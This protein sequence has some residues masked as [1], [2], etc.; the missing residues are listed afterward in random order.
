MAH[1]MLKVGDAYRALRLYGREVRVVLAVSVL[2][3]AGVLLLGRYWPRTQARGVNVCKED[4][5]D[6]DIIFRRGVSAQSAAIRMADGLFAYSHVGII[7]KSGSNVEVIHASYEEEGQT[8]DGV[9]CEPLGEFLNP[10]SVGAA[11]VSRLKG[12]SREASVSALHEAERF[13]TAHTPFDE[14]FDLSSSDKLYCTEL[15]W[16][17]YKEAGV[18]LVDGKFDSLPLLPGG[19]RKPY[20]LPSSLFR[21][22]H[23]QTVWTSQDSKDSK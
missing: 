7:R 23:L 10:A 16:V 1:K 13:L 11:A 20:L 2:L 19:E 5:E 4:F 17:A 21:S 9:I 14:D 15:I 3:T 8:R 18:D 12:G 22:S 6:G